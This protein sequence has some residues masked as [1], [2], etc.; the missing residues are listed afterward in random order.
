MD[1]A[2]ARRVGSAWRIT[3]WI[4]GVVVSSGGDLPMGLLTRVRPR[5][6]RRDQVLQP[7][8]LFLNDSS[9][10]VRGSALHET[11]YLLAEATEPVGDEFAI[12]DM[13]R[14]GRNDDACRRRG[15]SGDLRRGSSAAGSPLFFVTRL[16]SMNV[17]VDAPVD[18]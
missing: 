10:D 4:D 15:G 8:G 5:R 14:K 2:R 18:S 11:A 7:V 1:G 13:L 16:D 12:G 6:P 9:P 17:L 3:E